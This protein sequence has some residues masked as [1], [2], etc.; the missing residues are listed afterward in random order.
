MRTPRE[1]TIKTFKSPDIPLGQANSID[2]DN[3]SQANQFFPAGCDYTPLMP[4]QEITSVT[5]NYSDIVVPVLN[6]PSALHEGEQDQAKLTPSSISPPAM[7]VT[8]LNIRLR[9][10]EKAGQKVTERIGDFQAEDVTLADKE[11]FRG[12]IEET[13]TVL[14]TFRELS[15]DLRSELNPEDTNEKVSIDT[16]TMAEQNLQKLFRD[17]ARQVKEAIVQL[18]EQSETSRPLSASEVREKGK[19]EKLAREKKQRVELKMKNI[20]N[21]CTE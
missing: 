2:P 8:V 6:F 9:Q 5:S 13:Q 1:D 11:T 19:D 10:V 15:F 21:K 18:I 7:D 3:W 17:N 4:R 20:T 14:G 12:Y 16:L